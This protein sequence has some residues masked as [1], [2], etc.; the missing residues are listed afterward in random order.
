MIKKEN[1]H[2]LLILDKLESESELFE[3]VKRCPLEVMQHW[4]VNY[5]SKGTVIFEQNKIYDEFNIVIDGKINVYVQS[6]DDRK[7]LQAQYQT[8]DIIGELEIFE[9]KPYVSTVEAADDLTLLNISREHFLRWIELDSHFNRQLLLKFSQQYYQLAKKAAED[10]LY[11]LQQRVCQY[12]LQE[13]KLSK[14]STIFVN[15]KNLSDQYAVT[16]R[17]INRVLQ[18]L[19]ESGAIGING[20]KVTI[21]NQHR[22]EE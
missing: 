4:K 22:L 5:F 12:L 2:W 10:S 1:N 17:S 6:A 9:R 3:L 13:M 15:K 21:I 19:K 8:G 18:Q 11:S 20:D 7:Y 16:I 14:Q